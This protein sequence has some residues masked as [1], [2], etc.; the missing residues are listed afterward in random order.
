MSYKLTLI[1]NNYTIDK[2]IQLNNN[3]FITKIYPYHNL[4]DI[5]FLL[6]HNS[7]RAIL[8]LNNDIIFDT[9]EIKLPQKMYKLYN[10]K[11]R[12]LYTH[13]IELDEYLIG[14]D[15]M[16]IYKIKYFSSF[17]IMKKSPF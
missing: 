2:S 10:F 6:K 8:S 1:L 9:L 3:I 11:H 7:F 12:T 4:L 15:V 14:I 17:F 16:K 13:C 5:L